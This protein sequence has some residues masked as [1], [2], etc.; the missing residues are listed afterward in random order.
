MTATLAEGTA[1]QRF[2]AGFAAPWHGAGF[3]IRRPNLWP[4]MIVPVVL[5][6]IGLV[7]A[8]WVAWWLAPVLIGGIWPRPT[9]GAYN[10]WRALVI[11]LGFLVFGVAAIVAWALSTVLATPFYD[12]M[13][14]RVEREVL[15][16]PESPFDWRVALGDAWQSIVHT[17]LATALYV[18]ISA[19]LFL[20]GLV[21]V[22]GSVLAPIG[23]IV[24][25]T[26]FLAREL[27][28]MPLARRRV[29][30][31]AKL[32][33]LWRHFALFEGLG[34]SSAL[35]LWIPL[36][37]FV[38]MPIAVVGATLLYCRLHREGHGV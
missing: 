35:L 4:W 31:G 27:L 25:T 10:L 18:A 28:D 8:A 5:L 19:V 21:P 13:A 7:A 23:E 36:L 26:T 15:G 16:L 32:R 12:Q 11:V 24:L 6:T 33:Y 14:E 1:L 3:L 20:L 30:F 38:S 22:V 37:N 34:A 29:S 17:L 2:G 9:G